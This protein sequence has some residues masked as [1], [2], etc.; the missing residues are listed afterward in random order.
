MLSENARNTL[1]QDIIGSLLIGSVVLVSS[2]SGYNYE[3]AS[4]EIA[5][6]FSVIQLADF[7]VLQQRQDAVLIDIREKQYFENMHIPDSINVPFK[8]NPDMNILNKINISSNV[9]VISDGVIP[10]EVIAEY[11][12][13]LGI[14]DIK[15]Y[16][17]GWKEWK[18]CGLPVEKQ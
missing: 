12:H 6:D 5:L 15:I 14:D 18:A 9:I 8:S 4:E 16:T 7:L 11:F 1:L 17:G 3:P 10:F 2:I 13:K